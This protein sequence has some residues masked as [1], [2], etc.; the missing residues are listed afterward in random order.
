MKSPL[1]FAVLAVMLLAGCASGIRHTP[2][3]LAVEGRVVSAEGVPGMFIHL[4]SVWASYAVEL[5][6]PGGRRVV[7]VDERGACGLTEAGGR[8]RFHLYRRPRALF[9][10]PWADPSLQSE[11]FVWSCEALA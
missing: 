7:L 11:W 2:S 6:G 5:G 8:Y 4:E 1:P 3:G 9:F 10:P